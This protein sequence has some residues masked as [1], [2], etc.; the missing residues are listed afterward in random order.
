MEKK[1]IGSFLSALRKASGLTQR[2]LADKLNVSDKAVS[3]WERDECAPDLSLI[4]VLAEIYG[5][6]SDEILRGQRRDPEAP[7]RES[8]NGRTEKQLRRLLERAQTKFR[9][10]SI[11]TI[12]IAIVGIIAATI[13]NHGLNQAAIGF[14]V[15]S[16]FFLAATVCQIIFLILGFSAINAEELD[17]DAVKQTKRSMTFTAELVISAI[18]ILLVGTIPLITLTNGDPYFGLDAGYVFEEGLSNTLLAAF[19]CLVASYVINLKS[20]YAKAPNFSAPSFRLLLRCGGILL[21][22][23]VLIFAAQLCLNLFFLD[24]YHLYAP[25]QKFDTLEEFKEYIE[26]PTDPYG[27]PL[28]LVDTSYIV[29]GYGFEITYYHYVAPNGDEYTLSNYHKDYLLPL[30]VAENGVSINPATIQMDE[31]FTEEYNYPYLRFNLSVTHIEISNET[32]IVPIYVFTGDQFAKACDI[33]LWVN[34]IFFALDLCAIVA[35]IVIYIKKR[36]KL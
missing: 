16:I 32:E 21:I 27:N 24:H 15:G 13:C 11:I 18:I 36:K 9:I 28:T 35:A 7:V 26:T 2:Q 14:M 8:D 29:D 25:C 23:L 31:P 20:G 22:V 34:M 4:P 6:T 1:T 10:R 19:I 33:E 3:R 12:A 17:A 5:V 30:Y